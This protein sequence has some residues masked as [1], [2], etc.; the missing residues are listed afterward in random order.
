[1]R[2][3]FHSIRFPVA[4]DRGLGKV[5]DEDRYAAHVD[6]LIRQV[7]LTNPGERINLPEFG[8]GLR[9][10]VFAPN[11]PAAASLL[12]VTVLQAL[13]RWLS[14]VIKVEDAEVGAV[15]ETLTVRLRYVILA[16]QERR[17]LN[18]EVAL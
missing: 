7:L 4:I 5:S 6:Q 3:L 14:T 8:C 13:D 15:E 2:E 9:R 16:R 18:L 12:K 17:Y 11:N 10:M 1:M